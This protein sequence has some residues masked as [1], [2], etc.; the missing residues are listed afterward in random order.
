MYI[1][2]QIKYLL[3]SLSLNPLQI[4]TLSKLNQPMFWIQYIYKILRSHKFLIRYLEKN[5]ISFSLNC[6][7]SLII[8]LVPFIIIDKTN[9]IN[10]FPGF[11]KK[12]H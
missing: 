12:F 1:V 9:F 2:I 10:T 8:Y 11:I 5:N 7:K 4:A 3:K 6:Q